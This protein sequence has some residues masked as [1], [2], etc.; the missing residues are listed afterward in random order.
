MPVDMAK[1]LIVDDDSGCLKL[2]RASLT[3]LGHEVCEAHDGD[4][5]LQAHVSWR[6]ELV[7]LDVLMPEKDGIETLRE[8]HAIEPTLPIV[9]MSDGGSIGLS[10]CIDV[11]PTLGATGLLIKPFGVNELART[12]E[13]AL[14]LSVAAAQRRHIASPRGSHVP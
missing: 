14:A 4:V 9:A 6:P 11:M 7:L 8:L 3:V 13:A 12:V 1:I 10:I 5:A 2:L